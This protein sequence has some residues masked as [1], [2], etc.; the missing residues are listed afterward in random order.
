MYSNRIDELI[1]QFYGVHDSPGVRD[2][3]EVVARAITDYYVTYNYETA[4]TPPDVQMTLDLEHAGRGN[5][6]EMGFVVACVNTRKV[7]LGGEFLCPGEMKMIRRNSF[8]TE[9]RIAKTAADIESDASIK[10]A[11]SYTVRFESS[12][13]MAH[14][15]RALLDVA[16][17]CKPRL[18]PG[19]TGLLAQRVVP[20]WNGVSMWGLSPATLYNATDAEMDAWETS[21]PR[22]W[23]PIVVNVDTSTAEACNVADMFTRAGVVDPPQFM[24]GSFCDDGWHAHRDIVANMM[25][26][27]HRGINDAMWIMWM[28]MQK[29]ASYLQA[30]SENPQARFARV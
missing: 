11:P 9:E 25:T 3:L 26:S 18:T 19:A 15:F 28:V 5:V 20:C 21:W 14:A 12:A 6:F 24:A 17:Y 8:W 1:K 13:D 4:R 30:A 27:A 22:G 2:L 16:S 7:L 23:A 29:R 10:G